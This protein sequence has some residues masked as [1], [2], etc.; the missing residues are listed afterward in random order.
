MS[1]AAPAVAEVQRLR[2]SS[3]SWNT[4]VGISDLLGDRPLRMTYDRGELE[5]MTLS[6][7]HERFKRLLARMLDTLTEEMDIDIDHGGSMTF[8]REDLDRGLEPDECYWVQN[9]ARV[10]GREEL[11]F[12]VDPAPDLVLEVEV[13]R[14][15]ID[16]QG[17]C[18]ALGIPEVWRF[19][20]Q[21]IQ[22]L[23]RNDL[24][25][26]DLAERSAAFPFLPVAQLT[27]F[28]TMNETVSVTK[29]LQA[30]RAWV[31]ERMANNWQ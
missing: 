14:N 6:R 18:A 13:T 8:R 27:Q 21:T 25:G 30:F 15:I 10:R 29:V 20:G 7:A 28:L 16:R 22:I 1:T 3:V 31:R 4:Y 19:D 26:Y 17:I 5:I 2:L 9:E 23:L 12:T 24:G 11:D